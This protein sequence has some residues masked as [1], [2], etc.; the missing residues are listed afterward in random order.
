V[1]SLQVIHVDA[2]RRLI[3][4]TSW[5]HLYFICC[6]VRFTFIHVWHWTIWYNFYTH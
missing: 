3:V 6:V 1:T 4:C 5:S 2:L